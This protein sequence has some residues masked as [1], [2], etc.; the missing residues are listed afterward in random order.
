MGLYDYIHCKYPL[1][2]PG[3]N[4]ATCQTK[5]TDEQFCGYYEIREDG[6]LWHQNYDT[7]DRSD[8]ALTGKG[9]KFL[10]CM[11]RVNERWE[12]CESFTGE[13]VFYG[14]TPEGDFRFSAYFV[15]GKIKHLEQIVP[16]P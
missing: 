5:D 14:D 3:A 2:V 6:S 4:A 7:E 11:A 10:G 15:G 1:S 8:F 12:P 9:D 16:P 13:I